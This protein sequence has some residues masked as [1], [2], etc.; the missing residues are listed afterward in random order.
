MNISRPIA[1][2]G[3]QNPDSGGFAFCDPVTRYRIVRAPAVSKMR[4]WLIHEVPLEAWFRHKMVAGVNR[5]CFADRNA[6]AFS[7]GD[8]VSLEHL[9]RE[10]EFTSAFNPFQDDAEWLLCGKVQDA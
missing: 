5:I 4:P 10:W 7:D 9:F 6:V 1:S 8:E 3:W 2:N